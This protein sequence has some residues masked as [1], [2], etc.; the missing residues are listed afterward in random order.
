MKWALIVVVYYLGLGNSA[1]LTSTTTPVVDS[2][3][4]AASKEFVRS[5]LLKR[6]YTVDALCIQT[7]P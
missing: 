3:T 2:A 5:A 6:G 1:V 7:A 4:C